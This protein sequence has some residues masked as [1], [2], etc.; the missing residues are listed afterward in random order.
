MLTPNYEQLHEYEFYPVNLLTEY[1]QCID[2][3]LDIE[4]YKDVFTAVYYLPNNEIKKQ[5]GDALFQVVCTAKMRENY[6]Y[7]EPSDLPSIQALRK[8]H[9]Y[10]KTDPS[11]MEDKLLGAWLGR[12]CGCMLGKP[13]EGIHSDELIPF[14]K[15]TGNYP[16][17]R[18]I[19]RSDVTGE[20][21]KKYKFPFNIDCY[22]D[23]LDG[24][25]PD[26]DTNYMVLYQEII[27]K[28]G[29]DFTPEDVAQTWLRALPKDSYCTAERVA[30][31][32]FVNGFRPPQSALYQN[33]YREWIGAQIR[34]DYFGYINPG[35]PKL[36][37]E[38]AWRD[39][40]ISH[41]KN[42]IYGEMFAAAMLAAASQ[43]GNLKDIL[44]AGLAEI[45]HTCRLYEDVMQVI[46]DFE[47][48]IAQEAC[49]AAIH[50]KYDEHTP[51]GWCYTIPNAMIV[52]ASLL[53]GG[54]DYAKSIC[55]AVET[56]FDTD[57]NAATVG[58]ILGMVYGSAIIPAY[59]TAPLHD[60]LH[61]D[62]FGIGTVRIT[63]RVKM[64]L[65]HMQ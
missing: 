46:T 59:W 19:L 65:K 51:H 50:E 22:A 45:P 21:L 7:N 25:P 37:A 40:C 35:N 23:E 4:A 55:M 14:L 9:S 52:A 31:C 6:P 44:L 38:M 11:D 56:A 16:L 62:I 2:E 32:N 29:R 24:M 49:F 15:E 10:A 54:G 18:Y 8:P 63:D 3:G 26:D 60:T 58:S 48:G 47:N 5:L 53:Y 33:A 41:V 30:Y 42:G 12:I 17:H 39:A 36:A 27:E 43:T 34:G 28:Y 20:T 64:T 57:C 61:T 13:I 1:Q